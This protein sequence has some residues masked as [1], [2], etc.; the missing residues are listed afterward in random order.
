MTIYLGALLPIPSSDL[1]E[2][3]I[4]CRQSKRMLPFPIWSCSGWGLPCHFCYQKRGALLPT[5]F[6]PY[7]TKRHGGIFSAALSLNAPS[8]VHPLAINQHPVCAEP[9]LSSRLCNRRSSS[10]T[11]FKAHCRDLILFVKDFSFISAS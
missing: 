8:H 2:R 3:I 1:P 9:G 5:P 6:H 7:H 10:K 4:D 11:T